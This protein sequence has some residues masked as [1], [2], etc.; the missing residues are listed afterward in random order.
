[1]PPETILHRHGDRQ[2]DVFQAG[3]TLYRALNGEPEYN[4]QLHRVADIRDS[5]CRGRFPDHDGY[6]PHVPKWIR[7][8]VNRALNIDIAEQAFHPP[9]I[10]QSRSAGIRFALIG[11]PPTLGRTQSNGTHPKGAFRT[12]D[13]VVRVIR[14]NVC[15]NIYAI[16][17]RTLRVRDKSVMWRDGLSA[18][19][20]NDYLK[21][22][23]RSMEQA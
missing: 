20:A 14:R 7:L 3:L 23:F 6:L 5:I 9:E 17:R 8:V 19:V 12:F 21:S 10:L 16:R 13:Q 2:A 11:S 15:R 1:M 4:D 22:L 18:D